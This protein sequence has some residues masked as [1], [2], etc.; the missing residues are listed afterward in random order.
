MDG[1]RLLKKN[2]AEL[3]ESIGEVLLP[4]LNSLIK[5]H[6]IPIIKGIKAWAEEHPELSKKIILTA[7]VLTGFMAVLAPILFALPTL[8]TLFRGVA[9]ILPTLIT[10]FRVIAVTIGGF[11]ATPLGIAISLL[12]LMAVVVYNTRDA[13]KNAWQSIKDFFIDVYNKIKAGI[14]FLVDAYNKLINILSTPIKMAGNFLGNVGSAIGNFFKFQ[15][16]GI[17]TRPTIGL[18]GEAGA[19]AVIPLNKLRVAEVGGGGG[20]TINLYGDFFTDADI[21]RRFGDA[22]AKEIKYQLKL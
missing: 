16:G 8:I 7:A 6:I 21:A 4:V 15:E 11:L 9:I 20:V 14:D 17:V 5:D 19:E 12:A 3:A 13:W 18:L 2:L 1:F 10:L 22:L